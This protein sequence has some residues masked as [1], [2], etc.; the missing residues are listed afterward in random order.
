MLI[1]SCCWETLLRTL[2][3]YGQS[4]LC[5]S[6]WRFVALPWPAAHRPAE[7]NLTSSA[8][9]NLDQLMAVARISHKYGFRSTENWGPTLSE[10]TSI[11]SQFQFSLHLLSPP[12]N[13]KLK[14]QNNS[15]SSS[16][17]MYGPIH[18]IA[19]T[20]PSLASSMIQQH[21]YPKMNQRVYLS[22]RSNNSAS[23]RDTIGSR[24]L[25]KSFVKHLPTSS[26]P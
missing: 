5:T 8:S 17:P 19:A 26:I 25:G 10:S 23:S 7:L 11:E 20:Q 16:A 22:R 9:A 3:I 12:I 1:P 2:D 15:R 6:L 24:K 18:K 14:I 4:M 13:P 21:P